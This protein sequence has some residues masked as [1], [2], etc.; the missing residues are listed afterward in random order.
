MSIVPAT[1]IWNHGSPGEVFT[2]AS[3]HAPSVTTSEAERC[4]VTVLEGREC[5]GCVERLGW[6]LGGD[7][8]H[9]VMGGGVAVTGKPGVT[10]SGTTVYGG[11]FVGVGGA[12]AF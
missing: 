7:L 5:R 3:I 12:S 9:S 10:G 4:E 2:S 1:I 6:R 8:R 11:G